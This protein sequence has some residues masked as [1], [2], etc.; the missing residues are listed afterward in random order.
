MLN[1]FSILESVPIDA[2]VLS[3]LILHFH[4]TTKNVHLS[5]NF[6][7]ESVFLFFITKLIYCGS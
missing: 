6:Y 2:R 1:P 7:E 3:L 4:M 5:N